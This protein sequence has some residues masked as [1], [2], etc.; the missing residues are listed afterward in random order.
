MAKFDLSIE[1]L[2]GGEAGVRLT[3]DD[4]GALS[5]MAENSL[6]QNAA[7]AIAQQLQNLGFNV[8]MPVAEIES[9][10]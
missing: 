10:E 2:P 5:N 6:T 8:V 9:K 3:I 4:A 1:D 7:I